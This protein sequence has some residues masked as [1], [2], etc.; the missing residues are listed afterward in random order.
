MQQSPIFIK[1]ETFLV[2]LLEHTRKFPK[3][4]RF[5]L[6]KHLEDALFTFHQDLLYAVGED[7]PFQ[8]L[9]D[10]DVQMGKVRAYLRLSHEL[11]YTS[12]NQ[13][14]YASQHTTELGKLLGGWLKSLSS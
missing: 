12:D 2:W 7:N 4:E 8:Y 14:Q 9:R 3:Y 6:A 11:R 13:Y 10:A 1:T 5:R